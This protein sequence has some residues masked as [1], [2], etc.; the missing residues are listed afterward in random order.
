MQQ[1]HQQQKKI[2]IFL[3]LSFFTFNEYV[4]QKLFE[5][6]LFLVSLCFIK[7]LLKWTF[8]TNSKQ[9]YRKNKEWHA[10]NTL[11]NIC[12]LYIVHSLNF[13]T[14]SKFDYWVFLYFWPKLY[15]LCEYKLFET[16]KRDKTELKSI[17]SVEM[18]SYS[19]LFYQNTVKTYF[20]PKF[21]KCF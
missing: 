21:K 11:K 7:A 20:I 12:F 15:S 16:F 14:G 19:L 3:P 9:S 6:Q 4:W 5:I 2:Q 1:Q 13:R 8:L 10:L 17:S 18:S